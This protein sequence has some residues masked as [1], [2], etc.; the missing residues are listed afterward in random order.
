MK[1]L[2]LWKRKA[3]NYSDAAGILDTYQELTMRK[4]I[5]SGRMLD[6]FDPAKAAIEIHAS[7]AVVKIAKRIHDRTVFA[8]ALDR[9]LKA[10]REAAVEYKAKFGGQ[11]RRTDL[12][13]ERSFGSLA[14]C[15]AL[16]FSA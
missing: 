13:S 3:R 14:F 6:K 12:T 9:N 2:M 8:E 7:D 1:A 16:G 4:Q 15:A 5:S 10:K 11:G